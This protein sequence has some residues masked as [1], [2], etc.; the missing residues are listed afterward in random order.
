MV[1]LS[2]FLQWN[3]SHSP[4]LDVF[5]AGLTQQVRSPCG[6]CESNVLFIGH[7]R[8]TQFFD[9]LPLE[10]L[11]FVYQYQLLHFGSPAAT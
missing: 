3:L 6:V 4:I 5:F 1:F 10:L 2:F 9:T 11:A 8:F 7:D